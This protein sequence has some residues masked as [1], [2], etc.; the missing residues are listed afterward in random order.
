MNI[1]NL[2]RNPLNPLLKKGEIPKFSLR[3]SSFFKGGLRGFLEL[4][5]L[6]YSIFLF[7]LILITSCIRQ[8]DSPQEPIPE[9]YKYS[10]VYILCEGLW[11]QDNSSL[12][13]YDDSTELLINDFYGKVNPDLRLGDV[14]NDIVLLGNTAY[15]AVT[16]SKTIETFNVRTGKSTGRIILNGNRAPRKICIINDTIAYVTDLYA[17]CLTKFNPRKSQILIDRIPVGPAPE[18][19]V[20]DGKFLY[21]ANSG[22]GDYLAKEPKAGTFSVVDILSDKEI[23]TVYV[24]PNLV[25]LAINNK[26]NRLY[27]LY[28]H[29]PSLVDS[30]G[31]IV[32]YDVSTLKELR[33]WRISA[34]SL[35]LSITGDSLF[36]IKDRN[37]AMM[38]LKQANTEIKILVENPAKNEF[39]KAIGISPTRNE[40]WIGNDKNFQISGEVLIYSF[41]NLS[42]PLKRFNVG[43]NPNSIIFF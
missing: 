22:Y 15:V 14:A 27:A 19:I 26:N 17:K 11:N 18:A 13:R 30:V 24:G 4:S 36:F 28:Y 8:P 21:V 32:E 41:D 25:E 40:I 16:T 2:N 31:C 34:I 12:S 37:L 38:D 42:I 7:N 20:T 9:N 3:F 35:K 5:N 39:W 33:R 43:L 6:I 29:L 23:K 1:N 10:G